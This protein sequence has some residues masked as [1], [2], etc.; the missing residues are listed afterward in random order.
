M[1]KGAD[2]GMSKKKKN[3][4]AAGFNKIYLILAVAAIFVFVGYRFIL[5]QNNDTKDASYLSQGTIDG[6]DL[7]LAKADVTEKASFYA[8]DKAGTY[9]EV[10]AVKASDGSVRTAL[11]TCQVCYD[12]GQGYYKQEGSTLVCQ[13][14]GNVFGIDE[15]ELIKG[16]CNPV[17]IM[18]ENKT[19]D[20]EYITISGQFLADNKSYFERW[21]R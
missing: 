5:P 11:N 14:C 6:V 4:E 18:Q 7:K 1:M 13:N 21:K 2:E 3:N 9:M 12:S 20:G 8:Y 19:E 10:I 15:L 16:G 17:P